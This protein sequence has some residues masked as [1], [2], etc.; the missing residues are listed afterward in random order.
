MHL[1][2]SLSCHQVSDRDPSKESLLSGGR[3]GSRLDRGDYWDFQVLEAVRGDPHRPRHLVL[4]LRGH[5]DK[6]SFRHPAL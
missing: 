1:P 3:E 2:R 5:R 6:L 4:R